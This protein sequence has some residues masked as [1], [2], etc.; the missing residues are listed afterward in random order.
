[1]ALGCAIFAIAVAD[2]L[3]ATLRGERQRH[4]A[5]DGEPVRSE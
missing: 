2:E 5:A 3:V 1:M 4:R